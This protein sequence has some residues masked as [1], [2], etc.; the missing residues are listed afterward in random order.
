VFLEKAGGC[1]IEPLARFLF[2]QLVIALDYCH[3][4]GKISRDIK[5]SGLLLQLSASALPL[6][7]MSDFAVSKDT[8][9]NSEPRSQASAWH[10][11]CNEARGA[12][13]GAATEATGLGRAAV[14]GLGSAAAVLTSGVPRRTRG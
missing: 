4:K 5:P 10:R 12:L 6:L 14:A 8:L 13:V 3:R 7:K 11:I 2:Q 1:V 9:R